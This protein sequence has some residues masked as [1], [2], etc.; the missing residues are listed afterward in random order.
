MATLFLLMED[1]S[2]MCDLIPWQISKQRNYI[3]LQVHHFIV[4]KSRMNFNF[5]DFM[6]FAKLIGTSENNMISI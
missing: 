1:V 2:K 5:K 3:I 4:V 6:H